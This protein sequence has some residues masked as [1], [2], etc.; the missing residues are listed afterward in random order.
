MYGITF[1]G[2]I[3]FTI[4]SSYGLFFL[5]NFFFQYLTFIPILFYDIED[6]KKQIA[7]GGI[8]ILFSLFI[9]NI[10]VIPTFDFFSLPFINFQN[11]INYFYSFQF[12]NH[13]VEIDSKK[14]REQNSKHIN[15]FLIFIEIFYILGLIL[16]LSSITTLIKD[17]IDFFILL[18]VY[19]YYLI[20]IFCYFFV[21]LIIIYRSS[22]G[23]KKLPQKISEINLFSYAINPI[24]K[25]NYENADNLKEIFWTKRN[26]LRLFFLP[27]VIFFFLGFYFKNI[28]KILFI[29]ILTIFIFP[30]TIAFNFPLYYL[31][32]KISSI[33][34]F[35][36]SK[37]KL[38]EDLQPKHPIMV[39]SIRFIS[40]LL[41][42]GISFILCLAFFG[43]SQ[44]VEDSKDF[45]NFPNITTN[46][47]IN[48]FD[49]PLLP[50]IC[51]ND[52]YGMPLY[53]YIFFIN[54]AYYYNE[55]GKNKSSFDFPKYKN[56]FFDEKYDIEIIGNLINETNNIEK[57][58]MIQYNINNL[59][60]TILS[61]KGTTSKKDIFLDFQLYMPS[62]FLN[63]LSLFSAFGMDLESNSFKLVEYS[64]SIPYRLISNY[65]FIKDY[66]NDLIKAFDN[67]KFKKNVVIVGHSLGG[68]LS[69]ILAKIKKKQAISLSGPGINAFHS[70]WTE[71][72]NSENFDISLIDL[73]P[74]MDLVPRVEQTGGT[75]Y[76]IVCKEGALDCHS[77]AISLCE[78][79]IMCRHPSRESYCY[80][81]ADFNYKKIKKIMQLSELNKKLNEIE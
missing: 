25:D 81:L 7:L 63:I 77:K 24:F 18:L 13:K 20:L 31:N 6:F 9:S 30:L 33:K 42:F 47:I 67:G 60:L 73:V 54:D 34:E 19:L 52:I 11:P 49:N 36:S 37:L 26:Y 71:E 44:N 22:S 55:I 27:C 38:K 2:R 12:I 51:G 21:S 29:I 16:Y 58:K 8:Y 4:Y 48:K 75:I 41:F 61:I 65:L 3:I 39:S 53:L 79:L 68:G 70:R 62:V 17:F 46:Y 14:I 74:D 66:I 40:N 78:I 28:L 10:L 43:N 35:N 45:E 69:K 64:L 59:N 57:V 1:F 76:R 72:G 15:L 80:K 5:Y 50:N 56:A 23:E 32:I